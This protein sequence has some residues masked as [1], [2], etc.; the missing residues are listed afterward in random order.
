MEPTIAFRVREHEE[1]ACEI[2]VNFGVF[3]GRSVT[4]AEID[5]LAVE[6]RDFVPSFTI[7]AE[8]RHEFGASVE[9]SLHQVVI[10]IAQEFA[11]P[12][13]EDLCGGLVAAADVWA[14]TCIAARSVDVAEF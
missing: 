8:D 13:P 1:P 4:P 6:L 9:A 12:R 10:E 14:Q 5:D 7:V 2:R 3:A 11:G